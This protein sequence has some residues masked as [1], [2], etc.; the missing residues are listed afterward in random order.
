MKKKYRDPAKDYA[1]FMRQPEYTDRYD[2]KV[3]LLY[4]HT[5]LGSGA[6]YLEAVEDARQRAAAE[7]RELPLKEALVFTVR[8]PLGFGPEYFLDTPPVR[9]PEDQQRN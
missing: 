7:N 1:W 6:D 5:V 4:H 3:V 9:R 8:K 2:G